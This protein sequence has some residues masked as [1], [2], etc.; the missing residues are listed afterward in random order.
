MTD[1]LQTI[2]IPPDTVVHD[3]VIAQSAIPWSLPP[4]VWH[5]IWQAGITG[6]GITII[7]LDT[8]WRA[9]PDLPAPIDGH[10]FTSAQSTDIMDRQGHGVHTIGTHSGRNGIGVAPESSI[11]VGKVLG[12]DGR[13]ANTDAGLE[14]AA[15]LQGD[16][17][18]CSWGG[19]RTVGQRTVRAMQAIVD[20][21]KWLVFA[22]GNAG[23]NGANSVIAPAIHP[24]PLAI[25]ATRQNGQIAGFSSGGREVDM[26]APGENIISANF[27]G[28]RVAMSGTSMATPFAAGALA[29]LRQVFRMR[30][31]A[32][33]MSHD[34]LIEWLRSE[35][36]L[37][38]AGPPGHDVRFGH[39][40]LN[41]TG[42]VRWLA[43]RA[44]KLITLFIA[45]SLVASTASA[46]SIMDVLAAR[47]QAATVEVMP[48]RA[49]QADH[50]HVERVGESNLVFVDD[51]QI[52]IESGVTLRVATDF[53]FHRVKL[54]TS[55]AD[56]IDLPQLSD[57]RYVFL[58]QP[59]RYVVRVVVYDPD[60]G[61]D[62]ITQSVTVGKAPVE[63]DH[64]PPP[65]ADLARL[66][67]LARELAASIADSPTASALADGMDAIQFNGLSLDQATA[68]VRAANAETLL[69][70][71]APRK[72][73]SGWMQSV[74]TAL[75]EQQI[76]QVDHYR[77]AIAAIVSGLREAARTTQPADRTKEPTLLRV[78][79]NPLDCPGGVCLPQQYQSAPLFPRRFIFR[80]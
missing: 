74:D 59:G 17:V 6:R 61:I 25:S 5:P 29:L 41:V 13:G 47:E 39:G 22:A 28:G 75:L 62:W 10:N 40:I 4:D 65:P 11:A 12:D 45:I 3:D 66:H 51:Q 46:Q 30:G 49:F 42:I 80:R 63:P 64:P 79:P 52:D 48:V 55:E 37:T 33:D 60:R 32:D 2:G 73:W 24:L 72:D 9:H 76:E 68:A 78:E 26:A 7:N 14:W 70:R 57:G 69:V 71:P 21:G 67:Q 50:V 56:E 16:I 53:K 15:S 19:G 20:S 36:F 34:Q 27:R 44:T 35:E 31:Q 1:E 54:A 77:A 23:Y 43:A 58:G 18:T 38:D 8:G